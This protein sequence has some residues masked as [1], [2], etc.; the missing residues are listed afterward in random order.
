MSNQ[1]SSSENV[2]SFIDKILEAKD[3]ATVGLRK[4]I[5]RKT[6]ELNDFPLKKVEFEEF[7]SAERKKG[8]LKED[9]RR[10]LELEKQIHDF[11]LILKKQLDSVRKAV[12]EAFNRGKAEGI[13]Q[14]IEK[15]NADASAVY[16]K[17]IAELQ[18]NTG[19]TLNKLEDSKRDIFSNSDHILLKLSMEIA[20]KIIASEL[21]TRQDVIL[22]VTKKALTYIAERERLVI[23]VAPDDYKV[24]NENRD[25]WEPVNEKLKDTVIEQDERV[26]RGGCIIESNNGSVDARLGI[27]MDEIVNLVEK[28]WTDSHLQDTSIDPV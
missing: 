27:Q 23:R 13:K 12:E 18:K 10:I 19:S 25:F 22:N 6:E 7:E 16:A 17:N 28:M 21:V 4:I 26:S 11:D 2:S 15:G 3:P 9:E 1:S 14:G 8:I 20:R 24:L 5:R